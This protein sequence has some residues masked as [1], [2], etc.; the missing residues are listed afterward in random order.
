MTT[1]SPVATEEKSRSRMGP[2]ARAA[3]VGST[4]EWYDFSLYATATALVFNTIMFPTTDP[5][6]GT[7]LAFGTFAIGFMARPLGGVIFGHLGD[8]LGRKKILV[9]T[10]VL[11]G[12][13]TTLIGALPTYASAGV[14]APALLIL[15]RIVQGIGAGAEFGGA[16]IL[17]VEHA[18]PSR[19]GIQGSWTV[20]GVFAGLVLAS[21]TFTLLLRMP[22]DAFMSWGWRLPFLA[23]VVI[24]A[25]ALVIR[26]RLAES[27]EFT[28]LER[29][30][31]VET[32]PLKAVLTEHRRSLVVVMASHAGQSAVS[33]VYLTFIIAYAIQQLGLAPSSAT[34]AV[35]IAAFAAMCMMP[36]FGA[37][38]DRIG[39]RTVMLGG[40]AF[41]AAFAFPFFLIAGIGGF[42]PVVVAMVLGVGLGTAA[43]LGPS[44]AYYSELFP[45]NVRYSGLGFGREVAGALSGGL[46]PTVAAALVAASGGAP[47]WVAAML[48]AF[49]V[50]ALTVVWWGPETLAV[51]DHA[52]ARAGAIIAEQ[53]AVGGPTSV[54]GTA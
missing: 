46:A 20:V 7:V 49:S 39:R 10:L 23:S 21:L 32:F 36:M 48:A 16:A 4:L 31:S 34:L 15:L 47:W 25:V 19:R 1:S 27:P 2:A 41:S 43:V 35:S 28:E 26:L 52:G 38:S 37:L 14:V 50:V 8:R 13:A 42:V 18:H 44:A 22:Q 45:P 24:V 17:T 30:D 40:L 53:P 3:L 51:R 33:Y 5:A 12:T 29:E 9:I 11:M 54:E 6:V